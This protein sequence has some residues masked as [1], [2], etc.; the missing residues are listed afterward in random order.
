[1]VFYVH[2]SQDFFKKFRKTY[3]QLRIYVISYR[4]QKEIHKPKDQ[5][6]KRTGREKL[7][8]EWFK[9]RFKRKEDQKRE[10]AR[11][12]QKSF[13]IK[14]NQFRNIWWKISGGGES[15]GAEW[16]V[17]A[18]VGCRKEIKRIS[19]DEAKGLHR[20]QIFQRLLLII[21]DIPATQVQK[22]QRK[23]KTQQSQ[24]MSYNIIKIK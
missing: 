6:S 7:I 17:F 14:S 9:T 21:S 18:V 5:K 19:V 20:Y 16:R 15:H 2:I 10:E 8:K 24:R 1:M 3:W 4:Q 13:Q 23:R 12:K 22:V 11:R